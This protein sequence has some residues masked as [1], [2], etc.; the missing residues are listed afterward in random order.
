MKGEEKSLVALAEA[1]VSVPCVFKRAVSSL[2]F[3]SSGEVLGAIRRG[4]DVVVWPL[5]G[6][7]SVVLVDWHDERRV[8]V[9]TRLLFFR[10][11]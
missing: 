6:F 2:M 10:K 7:S 11:W 8:S 3:R 4:L 9:S 5:L 1:V